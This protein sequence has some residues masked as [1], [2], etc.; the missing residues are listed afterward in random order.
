[1]EIQSEVHV[2]DWLLIKESSLLVKQVKRK[3]GWVQM[4]M[5]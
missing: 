4:E 2:K 5:N 3:K 1:M